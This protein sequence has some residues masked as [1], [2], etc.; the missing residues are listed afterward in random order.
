SPGKMTLRFTGVAAGQ[1]A[2]KL[3]YHRSFEKDVPPV[4]TFEVTVV[5]K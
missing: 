3:I 5:V 4:K 2:L 1:T